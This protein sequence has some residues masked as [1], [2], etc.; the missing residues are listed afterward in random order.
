MSVGAISGNLVPVNYGGIDNKLNNN[1]NEM[2]EAVREKEPRVWDKC[3]NKILGLM[4]ISV[5]S[6]ESIGVGA[7]R[8]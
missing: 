5:S 4:T 6:R 8:N 1:V 7:C 2:D 3:H